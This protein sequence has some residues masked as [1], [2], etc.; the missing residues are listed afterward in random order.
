VDLVLLGGSLLVVGLLAHAWTALSLRRVSYSRRLSAAR[1]FCG[2]PVSLETSLAN[3]KPLPLAWIEVWERIPLALGPSGQ[4]ESSIQD[5]RTTWLSQGAALWPYQRA[6]WRHHLECKRRG[7]YSLDEAHLRSGDPFSLGERQ[8]TLHDRNELIV[9]PRV[10]PLKRLALP[11]LHPSLDRV[12]RRSLVLDPTRTA[13]LRDYVPGDPQR[14]I[15]WRTSARRGQLEVRVL[16]PATS[17]NVMLVLEVR[18]WVIQPEELLELTISA[19]ASVAL[20]LHQQG[21]PVGLLANCEPPLALAPGT[22]ERHLDAFPWA[23]GLAAL[24]GAPRPVAPV[25]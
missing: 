18:G 2:D 1:A 23:V 5:P 25:G 21:R 15:H 20:Y 11:L 3:A 14:L 22:G 17:L 7:V 24:R 8:L 13:A 19:I 10:V 16:E 6:R 4:L 12:G 9:Y